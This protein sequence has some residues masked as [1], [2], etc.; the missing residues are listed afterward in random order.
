MWYDLRQLGRHPPR[1][2]KHREQIRRQQQSQVPFGL[3]YFPEN[4]HLKRFLRSTKHFE[5][6]EQ[7]PGA[8][9]QFGPAIRRPRSSAVPY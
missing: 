8:N 9:L 2:H 1:D 6:S 7:N 4:E 3:G 5:P